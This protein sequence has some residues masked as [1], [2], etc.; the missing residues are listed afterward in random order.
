MLHLIPGSPFGGAHRLAIDLARAQ[1]EQG[2]DA[3]LL[4]IN[5]SAE[6]EQAARADGVPIA[7]CGSGPLRVWRAFTAMRQARV[8]HLHL[9]PPWIGPLLP[10]KAIRVMHLHVQPGAQVVHPSLRRR[11]D[12]WGER[13]SLLGVQH[14]I[15]I[16]EWIAQAWQREHPAAM[17]PVSVI[18]NGTALAP[19]SAK[20][21]GPFTIGYA[22]R[23]SRV[24]GSDE[25]IALAAA[26]HARD[27]A[28]R[29]RIAG[30][31]PDRPR[32]ER[33]LR[34]QGMADAVTFEGFVKDMPRFW[35]RVHLAAFTPPFEPFGLRLIEPLAHGVPVIA[36]RTGSGSDEIINRCRG[37]AAVPYADADG[38]A[39]MAV[40]LARD[41]ARL[42]RMA[43]DGAQDLAAHFSLAGMERQVH[44][45]YA[46]LCA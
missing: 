37:I 16:S 29:F 3:R 44:A 7:S 34:E 11:I 17:P 14:V 1:R 30:E 8:L 28:I 33:E 42:A 15:A 13:Q 2:L 18:H 23:L 4:T 27:P 45:V 35:D 19:R 32:L 10:K 25:F 43:D 46:G 20:P 36:Y 41:P 26:I 38:L 12:T 22:G 21:E 6:A 5:V 40:A 39:D 9:P 24:K 31:G